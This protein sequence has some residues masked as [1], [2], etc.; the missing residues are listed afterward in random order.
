MGIII[1]LLIFGIII[2]VHEF[3]H[4]AVAKLCKVKVLEFSV[5]MG[6]KLLQKQKGETK[7]SLRLLPVG[8]FCQ[9]E[10]EDT[11]SDDPRSY[12]KAPVWKRMLILFA[13]AGMNFVLGFIALVIMLSMFYS[14]P[15]TRV[16][17][18]WGEQLSSGEILY[19]SESYHTGLRHDDVIKKI[20]GISIYTV[21][22]ID[23]VQ[24]TSKKQK[25]EV[26]VERD[27][28][29]LILN[30]VVF[31]D[32][33]NGSV[34]DFGVA[35]VEKTPV[36]VIKTS[37]NFFKSMGHTVVISIK[38]LLTGKADSEDMQGP[39]G[40]VSTI[41]QATKQSENAAD[42]FYQLIY[43]TSF[44]T[45]N[46]GIM[47]LLPIPGLDGCKLLFCIVEIFRGKPMKPEHEGYVTLAGIVMIVGLMIFVTF[48]DIVR[49]FQ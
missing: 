14:I 19:Y 16:A 8:G 15:T 21:L 30:D 24:G 40:V 38:M 11:A 10:G 42:A 2:T 46:L 31:R 4:F 22:D 5:G 13:G 47:N 44:I 49:L 28:E 35:Y 6:P 23:F 26:I 1:A 7:Y 25:H 3:G 34:Y 12:S 43:L 37:G 48:N 20:D 17:G 18:F 33:R 36:S 9:F 32:R 29:E 39:V 41:S 45:I 27:G